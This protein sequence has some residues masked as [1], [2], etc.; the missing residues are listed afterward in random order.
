MRKRGR[1][2]EARE[3]FKIVR[4][5]FKAQRNDEMLKIIEELLKSL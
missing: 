3:N 1:L 2:E 4:S 5:L